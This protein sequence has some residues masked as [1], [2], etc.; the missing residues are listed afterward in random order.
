MAMVKK[1]SGNYLS[2]REEVLKDEAVK[3][4]LFLDDVDIESF[5]EENVEVRCYKR[6][7]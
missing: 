6:P 7:G 3:G 5:E 2:N 4:G 1:S